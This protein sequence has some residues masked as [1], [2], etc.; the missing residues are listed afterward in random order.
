MAEWI[1][2]QPRNQRAA[3]LIPSQGTFLGCRPGPQWGAHERQPHIDVS[4]PLFLSPLSSHQK[5]VNK[6][7][8]KLLKKEF[9]FSFLNNCS[10]ICLQSANSFIP[11][12]KNSWKRVYSVSSCYKPLTSIFPKLVQGPPNTAGPWCL[13]G[14]GWFCNALHINQEH[15]SESSYIC[16][17][18]GLFMFQWKFNIIKF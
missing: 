9:V 12:Q 6:I 18:F 5:L 8:K 17:L 7:F 1:E 13:G 2:H 15:F 16:Y 14:P 3:G 4:L 10:P 11:K